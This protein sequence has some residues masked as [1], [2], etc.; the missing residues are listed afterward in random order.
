MKA[1]LRIPRIVKNTTGAWTVERRVLAWW[2]ISL[3]APLDCTSIRRRILAITLEMFSVRN[4]LQPQQQPKL[5]PLQVQR[6]LSELQ[7]L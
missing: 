4:N 5:Q 3:H 2:L 1:S 6:Q 7:R